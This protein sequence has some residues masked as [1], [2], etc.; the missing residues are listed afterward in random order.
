[1]EK[2]KLECIHWLNAHVEQ[3]ANQL[4]VDYDFWTMKKSGKH[5]LLIRIGLL[6]EEPDFIISEVNY[7]SQLEN[8]RVKV[9]S[10]ITK[11][12]SDG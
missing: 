10:L 12:N 9:S 11:T 5:H 1:M 6:Y 2:T 7:Q 8:I 4:Q 3:I